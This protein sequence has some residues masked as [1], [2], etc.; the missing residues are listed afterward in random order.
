MEKRSIDDQIEWL[1]DGGVRAHPSYR[2]SGWHEESPWWGVYVRRRVGMRHHPLAELLTA[3]LS[4]DL[5]IERVT[6]GGDR[7]IPHILAIR[8]R[9]PADTGAGDH[10]GQ[11]AASPGATAQGTARVPL[12]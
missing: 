5:R 4:A 3:F 6:E 2:Q 8:A 1:D 12:C 10:V 9:K 7:A 11:R